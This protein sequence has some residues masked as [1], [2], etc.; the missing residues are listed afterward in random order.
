M[1]L[2]VPINEDVISILDRVL[3]QGIVVESWVRIGP[4]GAD[5]VVADARQCTA[6]SSVYVGY[7]GRGSW[8]QI[9]GLKELFPY[10]HRDLWTK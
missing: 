8:Q 9:H 4:Q 5:L 7:A 1:N 3:D 10:W 2:H 6:S